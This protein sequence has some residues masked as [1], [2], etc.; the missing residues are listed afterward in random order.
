[1]TFRSLPYHPA[2]LPKKSTGKNTT[3]GSSM[4]EEIV[5][6]GGLGASP[7]K[8]VIKD[9]DVTKEAMAAKSNLI[10]GPWRLI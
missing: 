6:R 7:F 5:Q 8:C 2:K 4:R 3:K 10:L 9:L 1:M